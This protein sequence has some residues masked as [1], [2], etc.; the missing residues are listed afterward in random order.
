METRL[1]IVNIKIR[2][3]QKEWLNKHP[4]INLSGLVREILDRLQKT[5]SVDLKNDYETTRKKVEPREI[6]E[7]GQILFGKE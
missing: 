3:D 4:S 6:P 7:I 5:Y 1:V 2:K